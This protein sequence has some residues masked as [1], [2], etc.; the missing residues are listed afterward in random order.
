MPHHDGRFDQLDKAALQAA[1]LRSGLCPKCRMD[2]QRIEG[3]RR[4]ACIGCN[5]EY[6]YEEV[7]G[8]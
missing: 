2:L 5:E 1:L 8:A 7:R 6:S 4:Y 3:E